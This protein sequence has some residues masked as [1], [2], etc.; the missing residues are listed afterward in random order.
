MTADVV[1]EHDGAL[2]DDEDASLCLEDQIQSE[3]L[4]FSQTLS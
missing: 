4:V 1:V 2:W 3:E